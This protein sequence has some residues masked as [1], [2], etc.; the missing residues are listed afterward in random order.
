[1]HAALPAMSHLSGDGTLRGALDRQRRITAGQEEGQAAPPGTAACGPYR[2]GGTCGQNPYPAAAAGRTACPHV[3][4][5]HVALPL[6]AAEANTPPAVA[7][8]GTEAQQKEML[9]RELA[10]GEKISVRPIEWFADTNHTF[11]HI[12]WDMKVYRCL[13]GS[14]QE[15]PGS[16]WIPFHYKW[17]DLTEMGQYA[18]P[19]VFL[20]VLRQYAKEQGTKI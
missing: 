4:A 3:G 11:S 13:L 20:G 10:D 18:F 14:G 9:H 15:G 5:P 8:W 12:F 6:P 1:M 19:K 2:G 17:M 16:E 7:E